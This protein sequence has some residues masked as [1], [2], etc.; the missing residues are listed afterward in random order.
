[1]I[2]AP[3]ATVPAIRGRE[4]LGQEGPKALMRLPWLMEDILDWRDR[5]KARPQFKAEYIITHNIATS[6]EAAARASAKRLDLSGDDTEKL[7]KHYKGFPFPMTG[8]GVKPVPPVHFCIAKDSRDH[9]PEVYRDVVLPAF[10]KLDPAPQVRLTQLGA[11]VHT[12]NKAEPGLP[13]GVVPA[14]A[15]LY[16][17]GITGGY[18]LTG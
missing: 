12:Y 9:S 17:R 10:A 1:M 15:E 16:H 2:S 3:G 18:F 7:V 5:T 14:V 8:E 11:G 4:V 6:L 13:L